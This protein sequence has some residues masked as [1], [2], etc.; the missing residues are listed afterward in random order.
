MYSDYQD[1]QGGT[2]A[3]GIHTGVMA[4][5]I[6]VTLTTYAGVDLKEKILTIQPNL[7]EHWTS[8]TFNL[9]HRGLHYG[10]K[11]KRRQK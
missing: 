5:T 11:T 7:P 4:A 9:Q 6:Y 10:L 1:I 2:T 8:M 3:E